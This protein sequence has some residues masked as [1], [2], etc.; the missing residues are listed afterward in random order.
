[1]YP[2]LDLD[3]LPPVEKRKPAVEETVN[4]E[5]DFDAVANKSR[6]PK[7]PAA[8]IE[9]ESTPPPAVAAPE[10]DIEAELR[11]ELAGMKKAKSHG[12]KQRNGGQ[13]KSKTPTTPIVSAFRYIETGTECR[14]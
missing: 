7:S 11:A 1:M 3:N 8:E 13:E 12:S 6:S 9:K 14:E 10:N 5:D 4:N 2:D